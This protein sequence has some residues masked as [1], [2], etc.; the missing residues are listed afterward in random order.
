[1]IIDR[2]KF[3]GSRHWTENFD[4]LTR[5][6]I[7][8]SGPDIRT[9]MRRNKVTIKELSKRTQFTQKRVRQVRNYG[10]KD[11]YAIRD[12]VQAIT[13]TDPGNYLLIP[14]YIKESKSTLPEPRI[15]RPRAVRPSPFRLDAT[16]QLRDILK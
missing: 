15:P 9:M 1:M 2:S 13:G 10:L 11:A 5:A 14:S 12:W 6:G 16:E 4:A 7:F 3:D 8:L